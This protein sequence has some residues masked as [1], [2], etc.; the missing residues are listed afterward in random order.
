VD[1]DDLPLGPYGSPAGG[2]YS[3]TGVTANTFSPSTAGVG[4]YSIVYTYTNPVT[5]CTQSTNG[6][7]IVR[8]LP[9]PAFVASPSVS[10]LANAAIHF[11]DQ[12]PDAVDWNW[13]FGD[14]DSLLHIQNPTHTYNDTGTFIITL[15]TQNQYGCQL[16]DSNNVVIGPDL[17][18]FI[19]TAFSPNGDGNND[20][21]Y[22]G[23][24]FGFYQFHM[25]IFDRWGNAI[26]ETTDHSKGW[27]GSN[28]SQG[29]YIYHITMMDMNGKPYEYFGNISV[30]K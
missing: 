16:S 4:T 7:I 10:T 8:P 11:V 27:D 17:L 18:F 22:G 5:T 20:M 29:V 30:I 28:A 15:T 6:P 26:F 2:T 21:F 9:A 1:A 24:G 23:S 13:Q 3:G 12:S 19:P 14:G 25:V